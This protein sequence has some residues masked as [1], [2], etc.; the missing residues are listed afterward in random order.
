MNQPDVVVVG[1]GHTALAAAAY[2]ARG[3]REVLDLLCGAGS[4]RGGAVSGIGGHNAA[5]A[6][7]EG[8]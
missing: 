8:R 7:P 2:L 1:G 3:G 4:R 6:V 5:T